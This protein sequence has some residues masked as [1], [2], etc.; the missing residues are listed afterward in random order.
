[1]KKEKSEK[2]GNRKKKQWL[3]PPYPWGIH[4]KTPGGCLKPQIVLNCIY[5]FFP[6]YPDLYTYIPMSVMTYIHTYL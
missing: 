5:N 6:I 4:Y 1:M 3:V 2:R